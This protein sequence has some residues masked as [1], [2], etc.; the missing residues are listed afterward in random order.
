S[1]S[2]LGDVHAVPDV[3]ALRALQ[4]KRGPDGALRA[5]LLE[6][7]ARPNDGGG[8]LFVWSEA[9]ALDDGGTVLN[10]EGLGRAEAGG[11]RVFA[12]PRRVRWFGA[13]GAGIDDDGAAFEA[14]LASAWSSGGAVY[15]PAGRYAFARTL[16]LKHKTVLF[17]DGDDSC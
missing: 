6:G 11:R 1:E 4:G 2:L 9:P 15:V 5:A 16:E 10:G 17:G 7:H 12:G 3:R 8:G 14:A 13:T